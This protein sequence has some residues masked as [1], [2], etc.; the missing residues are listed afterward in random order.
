MTNTIQSEIKRH[1]KHPRSTGGISRRTRYSYS[2][3]LMNG[4]RVRSESSDVWEP[5]GMRGERRE[6]K[7]DTGDRIGWSVESPNTDLNPVPLT[8]PRGTGSRSRNTTITRPTPRTATYST[9][10]ATAFRYRLRYRYRFRFLLP[11][12]VLGS[13]TDLLKEDPIHP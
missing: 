6:R 7:G 13:N 2:Y 1:R 4:P 3:I 9:A 11:L 5:L 12:S 8:G 10:T